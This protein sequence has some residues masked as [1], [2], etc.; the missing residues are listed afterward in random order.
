MLAE[1]RAKMGVTKTSFLFLLRTC[2]LSFS[3]KLYAKVESRVLGAESSKMIFFE[4]HRSIALTEVI[5]HVLL[6]ILR[7]NVTFSSWLILRS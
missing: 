4:Y 7:F 2:P 3:K 5:S 1:K 6:F